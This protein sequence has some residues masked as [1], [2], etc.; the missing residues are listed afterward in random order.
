MERRFPV[1][2]QKGEDGKYIAECPIIEGCFSQGDTIE[3]ALE[4]IKEAIQLCLE[5][6]NP[7]ERPTPIILLTEVAV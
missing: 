3:E 6:D 2:I 7:E 4:N 5:T 1:L